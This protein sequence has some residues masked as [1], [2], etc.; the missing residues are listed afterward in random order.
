M[1]C[2]HRFLNGRR[3]LQL[4]N[5]W[6]ALL[7]AFEMQILKNKKIRRWEKKNDS[8]ARLIELSAYVLFVCVYWYCLKKKI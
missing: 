7:V 3:S 5:C 1:K 8:S 4:Q 2:K 6:S